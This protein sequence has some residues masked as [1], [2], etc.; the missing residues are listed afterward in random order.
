[1]PDQDISKNFLNSLEGLEEDL[2]QIIYPATQCFIS[3]IIARV[4]LQQSGQAS[5]FTLETVI[6]DI[7]QTLY[8][9]ETRL[10]AIENRDES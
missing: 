2:D 3:G 5:A 7:A 6:A 4:K 9:L 10:N 1:M 8:F